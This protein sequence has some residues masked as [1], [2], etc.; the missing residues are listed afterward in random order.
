MNTKRVA[1][2]AKINLSEWD[3]H[4]DSDVVNK[5]ITDAVTSAI[6]DVLNQYPPSLSLPIYWPDSDGNGGPPVDDPATIYYHLPFDK[7]ADG[8]CVWSASL[9][10]LIEDDLFD[11][12]SDPIGPDDP[13]YLLARRLREIADI[14]EQHCAK[15]NEQTT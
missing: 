10:D 7:K 3:F 5:A 8:E 4:I 14:I 2:S 9:L 13:P 6:E 11:D 12:P 15:I 1:H